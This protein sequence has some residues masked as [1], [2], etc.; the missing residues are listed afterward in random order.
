MHTGTAEV[1]PQHEQPRVPEKSPL[2]TAKA[3]QEQ[4]IHGRRLIANVMEGKA[5]EPNAT[6]AGSLQQSWKDIAGTLDFP[7]MRAAKGHAEAILAAL[8]GKMDAEEQGNYIRNQLLRQGIDKPRQNDGERH[9]A[10]YTA[11]L[12]QFRNELLQLQQERGVEG[13]GKNQLDLIL[14]A[15]EEALRAKK[16][17]L[18]DAAAMERAVEKREGNERAAK[19]AEE[20]PLI[21]R[22]PMP[23]AE[24]D[25]L[26]LRSL[27]DGALP[28]EGIMLFNAPYWRGIAE[29][30]RAEGYGEDAVYRAEGIANFVESGTSEGIEVLGKALALTEQIKGITPNPAEIRAMPARREEEPTPD[31]AIEASPE[32]S[33]E[34]VELSDEADRW[35]ERGAY[36]RNVEQDDTQLYNQMQQLERDFDSLWRG[37]AEE[38]RQAAAGLRSYAENLEQGSDYARDTVAAYAR[39][40]ADLLEQ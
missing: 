19:I 4:F 17:A 5:P 30:L 11:A 20:N 3:A 18:G 31:N 22:E 23:N 1:L 40:V 2:E 16:E 28:G 7:D 12:E 8:Q 24:R 38:K 34:A 32:Q 27:G 35:V 25:L 39:E 36:E 29:Q 21:G 14:D 9:V 15:R 33:G 6:E 37:S 10:S 13:D 26:L